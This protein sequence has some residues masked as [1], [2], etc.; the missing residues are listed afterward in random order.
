MF[1]LLFSSY[2]CFVFK[3][4]N[5]SVAFVYYYYQAG[6]MYF[7]VS[8]RYARTVRLCGHPSQVS[9]LFECNNSRFIE[10]ENQ[11]HFAYIRSIVVFI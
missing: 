10:I 4:G 2:I 7:T 6:H 8:A 1:Y 3:M 5:V 9:L 11:R